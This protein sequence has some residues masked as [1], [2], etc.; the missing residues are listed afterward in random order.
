[1]ERKIE[2]LLQDYNWST[3]QDVY[4]IEDRIKPD[5]VQKNI[6]SNEA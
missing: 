5:L 4:L 3:M 2:R 6:L 1:M